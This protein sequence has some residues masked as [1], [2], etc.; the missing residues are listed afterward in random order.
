MSVGLLLL[1]KKHRCCSNMPT[2][3]V[4]LQDGCLL[5]CG[6]SISMS[7]DVLSLNIACLLALCFSIC[8]ICWYGV[9]L[10][11]VSAG[12]VSHYHGVVLHIGHTFRLGT[13]LSAMPVGVVP[14]SM[15]CLLVR[16]AIQPTFL[17]VECRRKWDGYKSGATLTEVLL[18]QTSLLIWCHSQ[19]C[20]LV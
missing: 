13:S 16:F 17:L 14:Y 9:S 10:S 5:D 18:H 2:G 6:H 11:A 8:Y 12:M 4:L 20:L 15:P 1:F 3:R 7:A 19:I